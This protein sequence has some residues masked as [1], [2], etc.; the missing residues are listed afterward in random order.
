MN[1]RVWDRPKGRRCRR[2]A[3][4]VDDPQQVSA[5]ASM[6]RNALAAANIWSSLSV[7]ALKLRKIVNLALP[8]NELA[9]LA[10]LMAGPIPSCRDV[11]RIPPRRNAFREFH[12][13]PYEL[14]RCYK[15]CRCIALTI[16]MTRASDSLPCNRRL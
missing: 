7:R 8:A 12:W 10:T 1:V 13:L 2:L 16:S 11:M 5:S 9:N 3:T 15:R 4:S 14:G 6:L